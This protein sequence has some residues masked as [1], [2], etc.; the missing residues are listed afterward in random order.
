MR[1]AR[2][3]IFFA[4][5]TQMA[6]A[7][8]N[9]L[10]AQYATYKNS[11]PTSQLKTVESVE[12][13]SMQSTQEI[14]LHEVEDLENPVF[15]PMQVLSLSEAQLTFQISP[16]TEV[17]EQQESHERQYRKIVFQVTLGGAVLCV[18]SSGCVA[19]WYVFTAL[20]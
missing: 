1:N 11:A 6:Y 8:Q 16:G 2:L 15:Q 19:L 4:V 5:T 12:F 18:M 20:S 7:M 10:K 14:E 3:L 13:Q 9:D 17:R